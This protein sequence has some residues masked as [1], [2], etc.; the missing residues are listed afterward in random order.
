MSVFLR[1]FI[2]HKIKPLVGDL[3]YES[4]GEV[5]MRES[6]REMI[7]AGF[8]LESCE[9]LSFKNKLTFARSVLSDVFKRLCY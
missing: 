6:L 4:L 9:T 7:S 5:W 8:Y 1:F 2:F 3:F